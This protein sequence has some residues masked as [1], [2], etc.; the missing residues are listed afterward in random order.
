MLSV[1]LSCASRRVLLNAS[2]PMEN[3][4]LMTTL[5]FKRIVN[6]QLVFRDY[7][8]TRTQ[9][10]REVSNIPG[11]FSYFHLPHR[12]IELVFKHQHKIFAV[13][14]DD[15]G[16]RNRYFLIVVL[17]FYIYRGKHFRLQ[18]HV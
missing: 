15:G 12:D 8:L 9:T 10:G 4:C 17:V 14:K 5:V 6:E 13:I 3:N 1:F 18:Q 2:I 16:R 7:F 11:C